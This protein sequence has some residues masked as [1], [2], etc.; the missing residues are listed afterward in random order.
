MI[1]GL[2]SASVYTT[3]DGVNMVNAAGVPAAVFGFRLERL[4]IGLGVTFYRS[5]IVVKD[6]DSDSRSRDSYTSMLLSPRFE[7][8]LF[9]K[10]GIPAEAYLAA[11]F[12]A[13]FNIAKDLTRIMGTETQDTD[14]G[15]ALGGQL[16]LG[17]RYFFGGG[18]FA[19][20]ME[21]GWGGLFLQVKDNESDVS[22]WLKIHNAYV[23]L[24]GA[25]VFG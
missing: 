13:G 1:E 22:S 9:R 3:A 21:I 7:F 11:A 15:V 14:S 25:F 24:V 6:E 2:L 16:G 20:G 18:P 19:L 12:G 17:G 8:T 5:S 10:A 4:A 23:A